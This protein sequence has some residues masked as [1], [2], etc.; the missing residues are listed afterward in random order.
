MIDAGRI[1]DMRASKHRFEVSQ[2]PY[3]RMILCYE[4]LVGA[5]T[6]VARGRSG[7][8]EAKAATEWLSLQCD[9]GEFAVQAAMMGDCG[10]ELLTLLRYFDSEECDATKIRG[11]LMKYHRRLRSLF[12]D[13][14]V[15]ETGLTK[16]ILRALSSAPKLVNINGQVKQI[17]GAAV[18][19][20]IIKTCLGRMAAWTTLSE[21]ISR[22]EFPGFELFQALSP[23]DLHVH[24]EKKQ[25]KFDKDFVKTSLQRLCNVLKLDAA[26]AYAEF[27]DY[28]PIAIDR[29]R[30]IQDNFGAWAAA[31]EQHRRRG[32]PCHGNTLKMLI[33]R[34]GAWGAS[35]SGVEQSFAK[36]RTSQGPHRAEM[37][38]EHVNMDAY[39]LSKSH[40]EPFKTGADR[41]KF[42]NRARTAWAVMYGHARERRVFN[43]RDKGRPNPRKAGAR[44][45]KTEKEWL[46]KRRASVTDGVR[47]C[48]VVRRVDVDPYWTDTHNKEI[49]FQNK[50]QNKDK[51]MAYVDGLLLPSEVTDDL[52]DQKT[53]MEI[54]D[55]KRHLAREKQHET[56][57]L[58]RVVH[59]PLVL[60]GKNVFVDVE[61][62]NMKTL[63]KVT[64]ELGATFT[65]NRAIANV[66][67]VDSVAS[68]GV[69]NQWC[70]AL[71]GGFACTVEYI[72]SKMKR[73]VALAFKAS[74]NTKRFFCM[75]EDFAEHN[76]AITAVVAL[77]AAGA[78][79][80]WRPCTEDEIIAKNASGS[81]PVKSQLFLLLTDADI[82]GGRFNGIKNQFTTGTALLGF[83]QKPDWKA[84]CMN[85]CGG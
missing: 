45:R 65:R 77:K 85:V 52:N 62:P 68:P 3:V 72:L 12:L 32:M 40:R 15:L 49:E 66:F 2:R 69:L 27:C 48:K 51:V 6:A 63:A 13:G 61:V 47:A 20:K 84:S 5:A 38:E 33:K 82:N 10:D 46:K 53:D 42:F 67:V 11:E 60:K 81:A 9:S 30:Q 55:A 83:L 18:D 1:K 39:I 58:E 71:G 73:G 29:W 37:T 4:G 22:S 19:D 78:G 23:F 56:R 50:K 36:Q 25:L 64:Y 57:T 76:E 16:E 8:L 31:L 14:L 21:S 26:V 54:S 35:T 7:N 43:R 75:T 41:I 44:R 24:A 70:L 59:T 28:L 79:S 17:G 74:L 80:K 34:V